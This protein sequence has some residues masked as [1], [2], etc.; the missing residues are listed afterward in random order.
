[1]SSK[2]RKW[3]TLYQSWWWTSLHRLFKFIL[4]VILRQ[5]CE[6]Y[7]LLSTST[8][9]TYRDTTSSRSTGEDE[10]RVP[11]LG[12]DTTAANEPGITPFQLYRVGLSL[13][14]SKQLKQEWQR[15]AEQAGRPGPETQEIV[16]SICRKKKGLNRT[17]LKNCLERLM[18]VEG[19]KKEMRE[20]ADTAFDGQ[21]AQHEEKLLRIWKE[22]RPEEPLKERFSKQWQE[23]GF[24]GKDPATDFRGMGVLALD[25]LWWLATHHPDLARTMLKESKQRENWY[26]FALVGINLSSLMLDL[27]EQHWLD[28]YLLER[29]GTLATLSE[30][31][32][33]LYAHFHRFWTQVRQPRPNIM[34]FEQVFKEEFLA[35][36]KELI[37]SGE[38]GEGG[39]GVN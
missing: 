24:Q 34:E 36:V 8:T 37:L 16:D 33:A 2:Q 10:D 39:G 13:R 9:T 18:E 6:L 15:L 23:I 3:Q 26:F 27:L 12:P 7:R 35:E 38:V 4:R 11:L 31:Y 21:N 17:V 5:G 32:V 20:M 29:A 28:L 14:H 1:M 19:L 30:F 25:N 22:L